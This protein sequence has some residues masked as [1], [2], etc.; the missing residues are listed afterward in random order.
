MAELFAVTPGRRAL[1]T[2]GAS[3]LGLGTAR[4]LLSSGRPSPSP[5]C[6]GHR[7]HVGPRQGGFGRH[8][9]GRDQR[10]RSRRGGR[11]CG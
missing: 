3:G 2:G 6:P 11:A 7:R 5:I 8:S 4:R 10:E 9:D 1:V